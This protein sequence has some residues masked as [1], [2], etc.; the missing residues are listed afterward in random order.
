MGLTL[1]IEGDQADEETT[2]IRMKN[3]PSSLEE[4]C[5]AAADMFRGNSIASVI[6]E[7]TFGNLEIRRCELYS[8]DGYADD[9]SED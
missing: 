3:K 6:V 7:A 1:S 9:G 5:D 8:Y 4:I 2:R